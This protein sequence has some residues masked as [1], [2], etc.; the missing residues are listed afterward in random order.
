[1]PNAEIRVTPTEITHVGGKQV[2]PDS[3]LRLDFSVRHPI[4]YIVQLLC[5][6]A[7]RGSKWGARGKLKPE[8]LQSQ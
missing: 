7:G 1:M 4:F 5:C 8:G 3:C 6:R 2:N